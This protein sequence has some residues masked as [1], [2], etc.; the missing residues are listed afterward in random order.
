[1]RRDSRDRESCGGGTGRGSGSGREV[2]GVEHGGELASER[3]ASKL[4]RVHNLQNRLVFLLL[5]VCSVAI[6]I[7]AS[8][9]RRVL[10]LRAVLGAGKVLED[11]CGV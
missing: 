4:A 3:S 2:G 6:I 10:H 5:S 11:G 8:R 1:V 9:R 7:A